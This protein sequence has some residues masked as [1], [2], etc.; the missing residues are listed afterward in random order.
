MC[1]QNASI[2]W[3]KDFDMSEFDV[4]CVFKFCIK[5]YLRKTWRTREYLDFSCIYAN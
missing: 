5:T 1:F 3:A 4:I 2:G